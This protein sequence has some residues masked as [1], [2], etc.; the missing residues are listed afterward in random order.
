MEKYKLGWE[1]LGRRPFTGA[2]NGDEANN[3]KE[4]DYNSYDDAEGYWV[5]ENGSLIEDM[6]S[7][8]ASRVAPNT[9]GRLG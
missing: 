3:N 4:K 8:P 2:F 6:V 5:H 7:A 1:V 9:D